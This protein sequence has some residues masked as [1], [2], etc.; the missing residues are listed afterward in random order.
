MTGNTIR[1]SAKGV[2]SRW[3]I[4]PIAALIAIL[5]GATLPGIGVAQV[6]PVPSDTIP[7]DAAPPV[8]DPVTPA[9]PA[10]S[11]GNIQPDTLPTSPDTIPVSPDPAPDAPLDTI[12]GMAGPDAAGD[13]VPDLPREPA[14]DAYADSVRRALRSLP[15]FVVTEY[16]GESATYRTD[17]GVLRLEGSA[18]ISRAGDQLFADTVEYSED[19]ELVTAIGNA[20]VLSGS[21]DIEGRT[22]YYDV[23]RRRATALDARTALDQDVTW[24][25]TGDV[26]LEGTSHVY[27]SGAH[28]TSCDLTIPHYHFEADAV[29]V[30]RDRILV[31]RPAR[32]YFGDVPVMILPFIVQNLEQGRRSGLLT[33]RFGLNDIVRNS[34]GY[35]REISNV[36]FYWAINDYMGAEVAVDWRSGA[37]TSLRSDLQFRWVQQFLAGNVA[38]QRYWED[39]GTELGVNSALSWQPDERTRTSMNLNFTTATRFIREVT[40]DPTEQTRDLRSTL[41]VNR[42]FDWGN[43]NVS[44]TRRQSIA[45]DDVSMT[46]PDLSLS[47]NPITLLAAPRASASWYNNISLVPGTI[48]LT[49]SEEN[50]ARNPERPRS[51]SEAFDFRVGPQLSLGAFTLNATGNF[52]QKRLDLAT[53]IDEDDE[54]FT[55]GG[56]TDADASWSIR[57]SYRIPLIGQMTLTPNIQLAQD[58]ARDS[59]TG[60]RF[61]SAPTRLSFGTS[62]NPE[63]FG[64]FPG[65]GPYSA[66]RH[67]IRPSLSYSF[68]PEVRHTDFQNR[69]FGKANSRTRN[70]ISLQLSQTFEAKLRQPRTE[71]VEP[72]A[73]TLAAD[74]TAL[75]PARP[76]ADPEKVKILAINTSGI[77]YDFVRARKEGNG[78]TTNQISNTFTSDYLQ[79][80]T[81][82]MSHELFDRSTIDTSDPEAR[83]GLGD[84]SPRLISL[85]TGFTLGPQ[86]AVVQWLRRFF[87][88][89]E[90]EEAQ[91]ATVLPE[92]EIEDRLAPTVTTSTANPLAVG[93]GPWRMNVDY[94]FARSERVSGRENLPATQT[95]RG[96]LNFQLTPNWSVDW[97]TSYSISS[98]DFAEQR[99]NFTRNLHEWQANFSFSR[100][101]NGN[102]AFHFYVELLHN[103]DIRFDYSERNLG[104]D[105][106]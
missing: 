88:G 104:I 47:L 37:Y 70:T 32:L 1:R 2:A 64:F 59:I 77:T 87:L 65:V 92:S 55:I 11:T 66:I 24:Y 7:A 18:Q 91:A 62:L 44:G 29:M 75:A 39:A 79:G 41:N 67:H 61:I 43:I 27:A 45:N 31:A 85:N 56:F 57:A 28:F 72:P 89:L 97:R 100:A 12:P 82:T 5:A 4:A 102:T 25:I 9:A 42:R 30:I 90:S 8:T 36:G 98:G 69:V 26:T 20:R 81:V 34:S 84:F 38:L 103:Q 19:L 73:D 106:R 40:S 48:R 46:L 96:G 68:A 93:G 16:Q 50:F 22:L 14:L 99:L 83:H 58:L 33:P 71:P 105:R 17:T 23:A 80:L 86:T 13:R 63:L 95:L 74:T 60:T 78:L 3:R 51:D 35:T 54:E 52:I 76:P 53:G 15:G 10:D 94:S 21:Q 101:P 49:R 6:T